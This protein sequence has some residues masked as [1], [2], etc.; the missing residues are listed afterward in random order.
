MPT[1]EYL[2]KIMGKSWDLSVKGKGYKI[3]VDGSEPGK[4]VIRVDGRVAARPL[5][6]DET[7]RAFVVQG[8]YYSLRRSGAN[9]F[10]LTPIGTARDTAPAAVVICEPDVIEKIPLT[11][12]GDWSLRRVFPSRP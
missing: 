9:D 5:D 2:D 8:S 4:D 6:A 3:I 7:Q 1:V 11:L 12:F 10:E